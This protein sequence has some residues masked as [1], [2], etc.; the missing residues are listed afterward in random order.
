MVFLVIWALDSQD[1]Y[2]DE[3]P[4]ACKE[5]DAR[6][7]ALRPQESLISCYE[8][9]KDAEECAQE[10][11]NEMDWPTQVVE[12]MRSSGSICHDFKYHYP[13]VYP[14]DFT[15]HKGTSTWFDWLLWS[16]R[17]ADDWFD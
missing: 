5:Y 7:P 6:H 2:W 9:Y 17:G 10:E 12:I 16:A 4:G 1:W 13:V 15:S 8:T 11:A 14:G 3:Y